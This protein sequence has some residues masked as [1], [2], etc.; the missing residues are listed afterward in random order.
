M[1]EQESLPFATLEISDDTLSAT[2]QIHDYSLPRKLLVEK[3]KTLFRDKGVVFGLQREAVK[4]AIL[5]Q[6]TAPFVAARGIPAIPP[7]PPATEELIDFSGQPVLHSEDR[8]KV[9]YRE[10]EREN[11]VKTGTPLLRIIPGE[12]GRSGKSVTGEEIPVPPA[13]ETAPFQLGEN[14][15]QSADD[16]N[17][18]LAACDGL[19]VFNSGGILRVSKQMVIDQNVDYHTGNIRFPGDL[20]IR[21]DVKAGFVVECAGSVTIT[22]TVE[23]A[24]IYAEE[25]IL[26]ERGFVGNQKGRLQ[27]GRDVKIGFGNNQNISAGRDVNFEVELLGCQVSAGRVIRSSNGRIVGG[28]AEA[29]EKIS[30]KM[31]GSEEEIKTLLVV[32]R[33]EPL[34]QQKENIEAEIIDLTIKGKEKKD[35]IYQFVIKK[36]EGN[37]PPQD[38]GELET[39]QLEMDEISKNI[40]ILEEQLTLIR[41]QLKELQKAHVQITGYLYRRVEVQVGMHSWVNKEKRR[42]LIVKVKDDRINLVRG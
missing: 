26:V 37:F 32:G 15:V 40:N 6:S 1:S 27:A 5:Q 11:I 13:A 36:V 9:N 23:D 24:G 42:G 10:L 19:A 29:R 16:A 30:I 4:E 8:T 12:A 31:A 3:L 17:L 22:G 21:G 34:F 28:T 25:D 14:V 38:A 39:L 41:E 33:R 18:I 35:K 20:L 2:L 7:Q